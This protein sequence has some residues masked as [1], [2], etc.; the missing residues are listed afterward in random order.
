M[1]APGKEGRKEMPPSLW[2]PKRRIERAYAVS[3]N[4]LI[5]KFWQVNTLYKNP[6]DIIDA[7]KSYVQTAS[8]LE[9]AG[10]IAMKMATHVFEDGARTWR[11]A[12]RRNSG[13][14]AI[15]E[16]LQAEM[17]TG[18]GLTY[19]DIILRNAALI[20]TLPLDIAEEAARYAAEESM[21]GRRPEDI[22]ED[23]ARMFPERTKAR[24]DLI[25][26]TEASKAGVALMAARCA[27]MGIEWYVWRTSK[28]Q[29]VRDS[30]K[31]MDNVLF[32]WREPPNPERLAGERR[33]YGNYQAG[34][35]FNCRCY[36]E[37]VVESDYI[38]W[39]RKV[40]VAGRIQK[41][42][43]AAFERLIGR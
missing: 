19:Q 29:R 5:R 41:M 31:L 24:A 32:A 9:A 23:I 2:E 21:K 20:R 36:P 17:R 14:R 11:E 27:D 43:R 25:A 30:H 26:R 35:I 37:P 38:E 33:S 40:H 12:A 16:A 22:A 10:N 39:P 34:E 1:P 4:K 13:G 28:D 6:G 7:L 18:V 8:F 3:I 42:T 15:Y